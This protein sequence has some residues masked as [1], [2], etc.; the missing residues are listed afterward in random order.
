MTSVTPLTSASPII[1]KKTIGRKQNNWLKTKQLIENKTID[2]KQ[3]NLFWKNL[4]TKK[5]LIENISTSV[6]IVIE[7]IKP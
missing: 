4:S 3:N 7:N 6:F 2:W 1:E 5:T